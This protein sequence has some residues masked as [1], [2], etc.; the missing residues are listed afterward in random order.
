MS[1]HEYFRELCALAA[2][3]QLSSNGKSELTQ[4]LYDCPSCR[5]P[6]QNTPNVVE[7]QLPKAD[8]IR[9]RTTGLLPKSATDLDLR[10]RFLAR[11]R[12]EGVEFSGE[13]SNSF[14]PKRR[15]FSWWSLA[16]A[17]RGRC[18]QQLRSWP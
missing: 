9:W 11:A 5:E 1:D 16:V 7:H 3:G 8:P 18:G 10:D 2:I 14:H 17:H 15:P 13:V 6:V 4:H 12:I